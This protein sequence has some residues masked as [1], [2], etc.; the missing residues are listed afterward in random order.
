MIGWSG[1]VVVYDVVGGEGDGGCRGEERKTKRK[2]RRKA[3]R[4]T[5]RNK[6][7]VTEGTELREREKKIKARGH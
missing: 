1:A 2:A 5:R 7:G 4:K 3:R 6:Q